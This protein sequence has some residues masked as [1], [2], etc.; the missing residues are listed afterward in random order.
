MEKSLEGKMSVTGAIIHVAIHV[1][2]F[3]GGVFAYRYINML[4]DHIHKPQKEASKEAQKENIY[5]R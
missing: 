5:V 4:F 1:G 2:A 3:V